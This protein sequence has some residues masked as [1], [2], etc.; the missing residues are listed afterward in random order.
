MGTSI[1]LLPLL[2]LF[3]AACACSDEPKPPDGPTATEIV[4]Q[5]ASDAFVFEFEKEDLPTL[6]SF[7]AGIAGAGTR[8]EIATAWSAVPELAGK[9]R[10][11]KD[12]VYDPAAEDAD[13]P[14]FVSEAD[15]AEG[16]RRGLGEAIA[17][18]EGGE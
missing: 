13:W 11:L 8:E 4:A 5:S 15:Y 18:L 14:E 10:F 16:V 12:Q 6:R 2:C 1:R 7:A 17:E 9:P 3:F